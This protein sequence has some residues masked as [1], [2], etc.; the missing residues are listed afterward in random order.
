MATSSNDAAAQLRR[1]LLAL[2]AL[3][4]DRPYRLDEIAAVVG[5]SVETVARDLRT[6]VTRTGDEPGGFFERIRL[7][8]DADKVQLQANVLSRPMGLTPSELRAIELGL[9]MLAQEVTPE[10]AALVERAR[11]RIQEVAVAMP[12]RAPHLHAGAEPDPI[13][14]RTASFHSGSPTPPSL[15]IVREA[16][17][18][19]CKA[20]VRYL[21]A[22]AEAESERVV[23]PYGVVFSSGS[24]Y[25]VAFCEM[26]EDIRIFRLDRIAQVTVLVDQ[27]AEIPEAFSLD[28]VLKHGRALAREASDVLR[29]RYA[30][31]I[32]R[33]IAEHEVGET[34]ADGAFVVN[35]P[36]LADRWAVRHALQ[37]GPAAEVLAPQRVREAVAE[38]LRGVLGG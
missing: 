6:L 4:G 15:P 23:R 22:D 37:Y 29:I 7:L 21:A 14:A 31:A 2:P 20:H 10:E 25:L 13:P 19:G 24:W 11:A 3:E 36:L 16:I 26:R 28:D 1:L 30:P 27:A 18:D 32:A 33:W 9:A 35:H 17:A 5:E 8:F 34:E 38:R 12:E